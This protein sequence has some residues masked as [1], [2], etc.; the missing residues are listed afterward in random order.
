MS[1]ARE[2]IEA[3]KRGDYEYEGAN[4]LELC[5]DRNGHTFYVESGDDATFGACDCE[6]SVCGYTFY[7]NEYG[8]WSGGED[9][10]FD[11][12]EDED[13]E[14]TDDESYVDEEE[15]MWNLL[16]EI[17]DGVSEDDD[18]D[19]GT[20]SYD[21][22]DCPKTSDEVQDEVD[23]TVSCIQD[24]IEDDDVRNVPSDNVELRQHN[25]GT[26]YLVLKK[27]ADGQCHNNGHCEVKANGYLFTNHWETGKWNVK[28]Y[29]DWTE[30][31]PAEFKHDKEGNFCED[32]IIDAISYVET[33]ITG[34]YSGPKGIV[35]T[36][37]RTNGLPEDV[38]WCFEDDAP[39]A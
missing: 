29:D 35:A 39:K 31:N 11:E 13:I 7:M 2:I 21:D 19:L 38:E 6:I 37:A 28:N 34:K 18:S 20:F 5:T 24:D 12:P 9:I 4:N 23:S 33:T 17:A 22:P 25:D 3:L 36:Y 15:E 32:E 26:P 10:E 16:E 8:E 27:D 14:D 1:E 30:I